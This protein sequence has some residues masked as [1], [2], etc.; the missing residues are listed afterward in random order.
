MRSTL[1]FIIKTTV[2]FIQSQVKVI[3]LCWKTQ[4]P[5]VSFSSFCLLARLQSTFL[6]MLMLFT[7]CHNSCTVAEEGEHLI[8]NS[9]YTKKK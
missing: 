1:K 5:N 6:S 3:K 7:I 9:S 2:L 8:V 4:L